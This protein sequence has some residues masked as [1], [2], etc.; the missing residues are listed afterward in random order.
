M[1]REVHAGLEPCEV[2]D[3]I[4]RRPRT[5]HHRAPLRRL[6]P[7]EG[8]RLRVI[9]DVNEIVSQISLG[10]LNRN[11]PSHL[12]GYRQDCRGDLSQT[13]HRHDEEEARVEGNEHGDGRAEA[14]RN[15]YRPLENLDRGLDEGTD[16]F[17]DALVGLSRSPSSLML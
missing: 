5:R 15:A 6:T 4:G 7:V 13:K 11:F 12:G 8:D 9:A 2:E 17:G 3:P 1:H 16:A 10:H 14:S